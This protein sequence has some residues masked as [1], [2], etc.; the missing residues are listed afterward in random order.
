M[1]KSAKLADNSSFGRVLADFDMTDVCQKRAILSYF[2]FV[3][4]F[5]LAY[6]K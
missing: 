2:C 3:E 4:Q 1:Q 5:I 6:C